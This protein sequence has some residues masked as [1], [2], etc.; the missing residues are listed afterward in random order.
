MLLYAMIADITW[1]IPLLYFHNG[2]RMGCLNDR[3]GHISGIQH[4]VTA[5]VTEGDVMIHEAVDG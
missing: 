3:R 4:R 5:K 2:T 1:V